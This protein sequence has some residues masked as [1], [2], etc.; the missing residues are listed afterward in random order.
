MKT[1]KN[2][3]KLPKILIVQKKCGASYSISHTLYITIT[4][5][6]LTARRCK[7]SNGFMKVWDYFG[8]TY[9]SFNYFSREHEVQI[10]ILSGIS[11]IPTNFKITLFVFIFFLEK[12]MVCI[13]KKKKKGNFLLCFLTT[14][15]KHFN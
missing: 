13:K 1:K 8:Q 2:T 14:K 15:S 3:K 10:T 5:S 4:G 7:D 12:M 9:L 11:W 6:K